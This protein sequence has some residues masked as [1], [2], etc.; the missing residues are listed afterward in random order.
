MGAGVVV[1][2]DGQVVKAHHAST[3]ATALA[4]RVRLAAHPALRGILLPPKESV[5]LGVGNR[6]VTVWPAGRPVSATPEDAPWEEAGRLLAALHR[7]DPGQFGEVPPATA[8]D[9]LRHRELP[10]S[11]GAATV[12]RAWRTVAPLPPGNR[13][14]HGD[15]HLGQL[16]EH[17]GRW[18]LIDVDDLGLGDPA[19]D[20]GRIAACRAAGVVG[21]AAWQAFL[22]GYRAGGGPAVPATGDP[23]PALDAVARASA[24]HAAASALFGDR[25]LD[26]V[27]LAM[28]AACRR[29]TEKE[30]S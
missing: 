29:M 23:W 16:V 25:P 26:D 1:R 8:P 15:W 10:R 24:V 4:A 2:A 5:P 30:T 7:V 11:P 3:D 13:L 14:V 18:L 6:W 21:E 27:D 22:A 12:Y 17:E 19:W 9:R 20:L 28:L